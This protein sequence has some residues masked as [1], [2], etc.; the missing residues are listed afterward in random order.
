MARAR[1]FGLRRRYA[2][3]WVRP[4]GSDFLSETTAHG[5]LPQLLQGSVPDYEREGTGIDGGTSE[6]LHRCA[7]C[8]GNCT[9][10]DPLM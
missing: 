6:A 7:F 10:R 5:R 3:H 1:G 9:Y 2:S 4:V 8:H